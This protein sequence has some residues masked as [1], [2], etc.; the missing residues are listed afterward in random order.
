MLYCGSGSRFPFVPDLK[1]AFPAAEANLIMNAEETVTKQS[2]KHGLT[3]S[4]C[5]IVARM[6]T[7]R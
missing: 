3:M 1:Q 4:R 7:D 2:G 5:H 6:R